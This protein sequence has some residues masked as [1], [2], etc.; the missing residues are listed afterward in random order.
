MFYPDYLVG[1]GSDTW[2]IETK[3]GF[4]QS[5]ES[6]DIDIYSAKKFSVLKQYLQK[7]HMKGGF[8]RQDKHSQELCICTEE[9]NDDINSKN[10][11]VL[12]QTL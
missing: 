6:Q 2:I 12:E 7:H 5:G 9:Y 3:G 4:S 1:I 11:T 10:W 8:V